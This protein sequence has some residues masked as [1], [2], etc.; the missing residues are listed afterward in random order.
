[1]QGQ[2]FE[3]P[4]NDLLD[5]K[6]SSDELRDVLEQLGHLEFGGGEE[7]RIRDVVEGTGADPKLIGQVLF[8]IR[9]RS[10]EEEFGQ[11]IEE[12]ER[13]LESLER[14]SST[15]SIGGSSLN[16]RAIDPTSF[17]DKRDQFPDP[18]WKNLTC[19]EARNG[20]LTA[21]VIAII[22]ILAIVGLSFVCLFS[23][24]ISLR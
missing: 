13:R 20:K 12:H 7:S 19:N 21:I 5:E 24:L 14:L 17:L 18:I 4:L 11:R 22:S 8:D 9:K 2:S 1:M 15:Q 16:V 23:N 3:D 6:L 10:F